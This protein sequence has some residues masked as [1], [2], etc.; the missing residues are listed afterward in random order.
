VA[1]GETLVDGVNG[2]ISIVSARGDVRLANIGGST[3]AS[4]A[5]GSV[6]IM[7]HDRSWHGGNLSAAAS[8]DVTFT[9]PAGF[10]AELTA[11][12]PGGVT[13]TGGEAPQDLGTDT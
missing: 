10:S 3:R 8:G 11:S 9:G 6:T 12:A 5:A 4:T 1:D 2:V 13:L 7:T